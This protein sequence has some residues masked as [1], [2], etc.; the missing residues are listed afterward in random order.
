MTKKELRR[1]RRSDLLE[2]L[3]KLSEENKLLQERVASLEQQLNDRTICIDEAGSLAEAALA[4]N[5]VFQAAQAACDQYTENIRRRAEQQN[6]SNTSSGKLSNQPAAI[7]GID[8][9][10]TELLNE[11]KKR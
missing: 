8:D 6:E 2:M 7:D 1:L 9:R 3:L 11:G 4:L 10:L 5:G